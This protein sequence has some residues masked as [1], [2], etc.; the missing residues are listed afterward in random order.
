VTPLWP[1]GVASWTLGLAGRQDLLS[2]QGNA[3]VFDRQAPVPPFT[4]H[5]LALRR[6]VAAPHLWNGRELM[7]LG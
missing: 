7:P 4:R 1:G 2:A 3:S 6:R 5:H